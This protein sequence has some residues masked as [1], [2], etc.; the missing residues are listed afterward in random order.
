[1]TTTL[2]KSQPQTLQCENLILVRSL[3]LKVNNIESVETI[4]LFC[5]TYFLTEISGIYVSNS[6]I[7][8]DTLLFN[9]RIEKLSMLALI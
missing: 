3:N 7:F 2:N 4:F 6:T 1:M 8:Q 9:H 5:S